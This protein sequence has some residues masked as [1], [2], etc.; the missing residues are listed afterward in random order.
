[1]SVSLKD[2]LRAKLG[3]MK[4]ENR[5]GAS[6][7]VLRE[8]AKVL[9]QLQNVENVLLYEPTEHFQELDITPLPDLF[10]NIEFE[11]V[12]TSK[13]AIFPT[14]QFDVIIIPLFGFNDQGY[15]LGHGGGW[16]DR[17][18]AT[19]LNALKIGVGYEDALID[20]EPEPYDVRMDILVTEQQTRDFRVQ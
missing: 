14:K 8:L 9:G 2:E 1:M 5:A 20:F 17:F 13:N 19:Q 6:A 3:R 18:L 16:Y 12:G 10:P 7:H 11:T 4:H 15:R